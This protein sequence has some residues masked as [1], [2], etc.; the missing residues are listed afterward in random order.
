M[1]QSRKNFLKN[2]YPGITEYVFDKSKK[3][4]KKP[5]MLIYNSK[6]SVSP[7]TTHLPL[8]KVNKK[9]NQNLIINSVNQ[10]N[11]FYKFKLKKN[12][13]LQF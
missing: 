12:Q 6:F 7:L 10:I 3:Y 1:V 5:V 8:K 13:K 9:I 11:N 2:K 4:F